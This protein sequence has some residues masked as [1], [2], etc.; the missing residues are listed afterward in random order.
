MRKFLSTVL[1]NVYK[2]ASQGKDEK[3]T[4]LPFND[5]ATPGAPGSLII[6]MLLWA[7]DCVTAV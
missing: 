6:L 1:I 2:G 5:L 4:V 3:H 7:M